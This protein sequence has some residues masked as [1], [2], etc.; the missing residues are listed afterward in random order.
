MKILITTNTIQ[1]TTGTYIVLKNVIPH[2]MKN[3]EVTI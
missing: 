3:N 1:D 2:L